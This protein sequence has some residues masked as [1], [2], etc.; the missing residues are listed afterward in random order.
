MKLENLR[1]EG[2][3]KHAEENSLGKQKDEG[4]EAKEES[5]N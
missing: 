5:N 4:K 3:K 2:S 1:K